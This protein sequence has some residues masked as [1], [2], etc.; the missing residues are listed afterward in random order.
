M[1]ILTTIFCLLVSVNAMSQTTDTAAD[2]T[3]PIYI[4]DGKPD[5]PENEVKP[6]DILTVSILNGT[7]AVKRYGPKAANGATVI[8]SKKYAAMLYQQK[9]ATLSKKYKAYLDEKHNDDNLMYVLNN[10]IRNQQRKS[11]IQR[12]YELPAD[13][14]AK[15]SFKKEPRFKTDA[16]VEITT[17]K[18]D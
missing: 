18:Q 3:T 4:I 1:K 10:V 8:T 11:S 5:A 12:L 17:K 7:D 15:I 16:T 9:F 13:S 14:I 6:A 2:K